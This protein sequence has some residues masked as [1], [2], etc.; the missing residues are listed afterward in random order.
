MNY[1]LFIMTNPERRSEAIETLD[2]KQSRL[3]W[4]EELS[5]SWKRGFRDLV[6]EMQKKEGNFDQ[7]DIKTA[8]Q[9]R[10]DAAIEA[11][12]ISLSNLSHEE[13]ERIIALQRQILMSMDGKS[14]KDMVEEFWKIQEK[15]AGTLS[16]SDGK[17][18]KTTLKEQSVQ[19]W[20]QVAVREKKEDWSDAMEELRK[21]L[22]WIID[23]K[24]ADKLKSKEANAVAQNQERILVAR[25][26]EEQLDLLFPRNL[27]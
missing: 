17:F 11:K 7:N 8:A 19:E 26:S 16:A 13:Q 24:N 5:D 14:P 9:K 4:Y 3:E 6:W 23:K 15:L 2:Q 20:E 12:W 21:E 1:N 18:Q 10:I 25:N 22:Q 27:S